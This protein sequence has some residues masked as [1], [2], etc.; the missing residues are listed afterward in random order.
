MTATIPPTLALAEERIETDVAA[1]GRHP[2]P[3]RPSGASRSFWR[4]ATFY[5]CAALLALLFASPL[6]WLFISSFKSSAEFAQVP[7]TYLPEEFSLENYTSLASAGIWGYVGNSALAAVGTVALGTV[8]SVLAGYGFARFRFRG[9]GVLFIVLLSTLMIPFQSIIPA[10]YSILNAGH[11]T[12][13]VFGLILVYT[14]FVLPFGVFTMRASF[15]AI[16]LGIDEA[17]IMDGAS[18]WTTLTRVMAPMV[19]PGIATVAIYAFFNAWNEFLAAL[20]F[21]TKQESFTLPVALANLQS[22]AFGTLNWGVLEAGAIVSAVP[23]IVVF[24]LLQRYYVA[25]LTAG[26]VKG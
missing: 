11:L 4:S 8:L 2:R 17:A 12:N 18:V 26:A 10:L 13:S 24:L 22:G 9:S 3:R 16:P 14:S 5:I 23:C 19:V 20:I 21:T 1:E 15:Q 6:L 7:P 25:G